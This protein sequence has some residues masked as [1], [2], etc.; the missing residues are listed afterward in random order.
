MI[1][2]KLY[3]IFSKKY[4]AVL[5]ASVIIFIILVCQFFTE[6]Q[7]KI[8]GSTHYIRASYL[9]SLG[10]FID[11]K[12]ISSK[13]IIIPETFNDVYTEYNKLQKQ[14]GFDLSP[15]KGDNATVY[16]Y[17]L[18]GSD[19]TEIHLIISNS[20]IIGGD[21]ASVRIDGEMKPLISNKKK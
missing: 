13:E 8:D 15:Y 5:L 10:Y 20:N 14:S 9:E 11:G 2:L 12:N 1:I 3:F 21:V 4:L 16:T 17:K 18:A 19:D 7:Q 6:S